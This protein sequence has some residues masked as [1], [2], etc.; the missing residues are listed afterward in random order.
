MKTIRYGLVAG[1]GALLLSVPF[2]HAQR[3]TGDDEGVVRQA[4][5][6]ERSNI[7]GTLVEVKDGPC[8]NTTGHSYIGM[9]YILK[10]EDGAMINLHLGPSATMKSMGLPTEP[11]K[12]VSAAVFRTEKMKEDA[13]TAI[14]VTV[15]GKTYTLRNKNLKPVWAKDKRGDRSRSGGRGSRW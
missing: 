15:D 14:E 12:S 3:G 9:H 2:V 11:G 1:V 13:L 7:A 4:A 6:V 8:K 5:K 10:A